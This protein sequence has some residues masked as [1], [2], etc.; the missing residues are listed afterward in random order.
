[1][2]TS[3]YQYRNAYSF[4]L[5]EYSDNIFINVRAMCHVEAVIKKTEGKGS[6]LTFKKT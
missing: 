5:K 6:C 1:M 2:E 3:V 4:S